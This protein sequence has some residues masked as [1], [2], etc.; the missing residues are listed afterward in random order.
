MNIF[1]SSLDQ[2]RDHFVSLDRS[3][4]TGFLV[5]LSV[6]M[7]CA[8]IALIGLV[9]YF[10]RGIRR[11]PIDNGVNVPLL[12]MSSNDDDEDVLYED[13]V[14]SASTQRNRRHTDL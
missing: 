9:V 7:G 13:E 1:T 10:F 6:L 8:L 11:R 14:V 3:E 5:G 2:I 12:P 4:Q